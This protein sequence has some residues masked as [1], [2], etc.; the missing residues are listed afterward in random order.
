MIGKIDIRKNLDR[1]KDREKG[2]LEAFINSPTRKKASKDFSR[3][4]TNEI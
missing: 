3:I 2:T 4:I 1:F